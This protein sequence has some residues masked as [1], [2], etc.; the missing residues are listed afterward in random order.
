[1][2]HRL[3]W[4][5]AGMP[6]YSLNAQLREQLQAISFF[7]VV[8][9]LS[10]LL[11][12]GLGNYLLRA[13]E[14]STRI[15]YRQSIAICLL[16]GLASIVVL[17]M[18]SGARELMTPGAWKRQGWTHTLTNYSER[19]P[20]PEPA[21]KETEE[22]RLIQE[23]ERILELLKARLLVFAM[24]H[25]GRF[26][27]SFEEADL[28]KEDWQLPEG[29]LGHYILVPGQTFQSTPTPLVIEPEIDGRQHVLAVNGST[30]SLSPSVLRQL[31]IA[32]EAS[33]KSNFNNNKQVV[34]QGTHIDHKGHD[35]IQESTD[36]K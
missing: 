32:L 28:S 29:M 3:P 4:V 36:D 7:L 2:H 21:G 34:E 1:M 6:S 24:Q 5:L 9:L 16:W 27:D 22:N 35:T 23:R 11:V 19:Q 8:I 14:N 15:N 12:R 20:D 10:S 26:P 33:N 31:C 25:G 30:M 18:I 17:T 13:W